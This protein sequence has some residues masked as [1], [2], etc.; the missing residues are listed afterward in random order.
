MKKRNK[1]KEFATLI[2]FYVCVFSFCLL[3]LPVLVV[4]NDIRKNIYKRFSW[5]MEAL[6]GVIS[7]FITFMLMIAPHIEMKIRKEEM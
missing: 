5:L 6:M 1:N 3:F 7:T 4:I 2:G